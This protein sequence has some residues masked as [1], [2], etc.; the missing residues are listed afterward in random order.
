M[1]MKKGM[2]FLVVALAL[3]LVAST[4]LAFVGPGKWVPIK[5]GQTTSVQLGNAGVAYTNS[6][7]AGTVNLYRMSD[8]GLHPP[9]HFSITQPLLRIKFYDKEWNKITN[10]TGAVYVYFI[11]GREEQAALRANRLQIAFYD[12]WD[13]EWVLCST[14]A[15]DG[16]TRASC[17]IKQYGT[18]ALMFRDP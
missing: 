18:Y 1:I 14:Q 8:A 5:K 6:F 4:V 16:Y 10:V 12:E 13:G 9:K 15:L 17:R 3:V 2:K 11:L 7:Y